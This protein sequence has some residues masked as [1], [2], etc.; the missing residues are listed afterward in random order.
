MAD[1][2]TGYYIV[3]C[4]NLVGKLH[5][6]KFFCP[7]IHRECIEVDGHIVTPKMFSVMGDKEKLKDWKNAC[8]I[9]GVSFR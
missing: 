6:D 2:E 3:T 7:G 4:G 8:R 9:N 1:E 5:R